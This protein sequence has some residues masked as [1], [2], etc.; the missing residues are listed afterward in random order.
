MSFR[1]CN[2]VFYRVCFLLQ[3]LADK[4]KP[5]SEVQT[6]EPK[7]STT[8]EDAN[9]CRVQCKECGMEMKTEDRQ[10]HVYRHH[11]KEPRL[12]EC[13]ICDFSHHACSSD[14]R[15]SFSLTIF[16]LLTTKNYHISYKYC[17]KVAH[18]F[19]LKNVP[20]LFRI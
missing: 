15:V 19:I 12:Y 10:I 14:V 1:A 7:P 11:L 8:I 20:P 13:P 5:R 16:T 6:P 18:G 9:S 4:V 2:F 17:N 3:C